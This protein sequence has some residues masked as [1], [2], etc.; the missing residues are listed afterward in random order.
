MSKT[1]EIFKHEIITLVVRFSFWFGAVGIPLIAF[2]IYSIVGGISQSS[3]G[4]EV[5]GSVLAEVLAQPEVDLPDGYVD[6]GDLLVEIPAFMEE[7]ALMR[8]ADE[9][10]ARA[11]LEEGEIDMYFVISPDY[12]QTGNITLVSEQFSIDT[13]DSPGLLEDALAYN[14]LAADTQRFERFRRPVDF[15]ETSLATEPVRDQDNALTFFLPYGVTILFYVMIM[16]S[17]S[18]LLNSV[19]KE[20]E[21]RVIETLMVSVTPRQMLTGKMLALGLVGLFQVVIWG[22]TAFVL[23]RLSG[24]TFSL[25]P[26]FQL[27]TA[28]LLWGLVYFILGY[29]FYASLMG[30]LGALVPN[31]REASQASFVIV[32][33][34]LVPLFLISILIEDP[35][36]TLAVVLSL[37]PMTAPVTMMLRLAAVSVPAWQLAASV[38]FLI[39]AVFLAIRAAAGMFRAQTLLSGQEFKLKTFFLALAGR[40]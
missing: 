35:N 6:R 30:G 32:L 20:K 31:I 4:A 33:P 19:S 21:N 5:L 15:Q 8:F 12:V 26:E 27:P 37:V 16:G 29:M 17:A 10:A 2:L 18:L 9:Q 36:G 13:V 24:N 38:G 14:L 22:G 23:L 39:V 34:L 7:A 28:I 25:P 3:G 40:A 11:A 1:L